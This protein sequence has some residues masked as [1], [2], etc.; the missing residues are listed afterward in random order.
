MGTNY[1]KINK[2]GNKG[3]HLGKRYSLKEGNT[4][5]IIAR[6]YANLNLDYGIIDEYGNKY[7]ELEFFRDIF[8]KA[9]KFDYYNLGKQ[10]C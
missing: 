4:G 2:N 7:S 5:F 6:T 3:V 9:Q 1:Y 8:N 10:F